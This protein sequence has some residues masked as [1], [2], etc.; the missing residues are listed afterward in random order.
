M[1]VLIPLGGTMQII[2]MT[3]GHVEEK[4]SGMMLLP[5]APGKCPECAADHPPE[6]PHN[7]QSLF[8]QMR[9]H[10]EHKR[11]PVWADA[12]AHCA[13]EMRAA[14]EAELR[15]RGHWKEPEPPAPPKR[16]APVPPDALLQPGAEL[17]VQDETGGPDRPGKI[18]AVVPPGVPVEIAIAEQTGQPRPSSYYENRCRSTQYVI[19]VAEADGT[20]KRGVIKQKALAKGL[21]NAAPRGA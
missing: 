21:K 17:N 10:A 1:A 6:W 4:A 18:L 13:P 2:D 20:T 12:L 5:A 7:A 16:E 8:Y 9:F 11:W 3:T 19:E 15:A 14:W